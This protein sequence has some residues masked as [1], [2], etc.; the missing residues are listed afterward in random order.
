[1]SYSIHAGGATKILAMLALANKLDEIIA[2]QPVH[3]KDKDAIL[4][5]ANAVV[6]LLNDEEQ[7]DKHVAISCNG[8]VSW[9]GQ[10]TDAKLISASVACSA[11]FATA[12]PEVAA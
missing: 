10:V 1:M 7:G 9:V 12:P 5:N 2:S 4:A 8:Y 3:A 6:N 11:S